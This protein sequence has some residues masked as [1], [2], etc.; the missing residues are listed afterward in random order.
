MGA[1]SQQARK[2][3][4]A[5]CLECFGVGWLQLSTPALSNDE[6]TRVI[7]DRSHRCEFTSLREMKNG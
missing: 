1:P 7:R 3:L 6:C 2:S 4:H 5:I